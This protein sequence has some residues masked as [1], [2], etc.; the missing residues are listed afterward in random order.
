MDVLAVREQHA[1]SLFS[2][3]QRQPAPYNFNSVLA[4]ISDKVTKLLLLWCEA[5]LYSNEA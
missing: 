1:V 3:K 5:S 4:D 2:P